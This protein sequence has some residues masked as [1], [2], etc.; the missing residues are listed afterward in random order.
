MNFETEI[1]AENAVEAGAQIGNTL[2]LLLPITENDDRALADLRLVAIDESRYFVQVFLTIFKELG[3]G[4]YDE[5]QKALPALNYGAALGAYGMLPSK[6]EF[7][8][9]YGF[10]VRELDLIDGAQGFALA[11]LDALDIIREQNTAVY[12][13]VAALASGAL[14]Y[15]DAVNSGIIS[16]L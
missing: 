9:K 6:S 3:S 8:Y 14:T 15:E 13:V 5:L 10:V 1:I 2:L 7:F 16:A 11:L 12:D 4:G